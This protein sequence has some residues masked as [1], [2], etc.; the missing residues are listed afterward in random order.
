MET[1]LLYILESSNC[2]WSKLFCDE[3]NK[4]NCLAHN[5]CEAQSQMN[6]D[7]MQRDCN[8]DDL[9]L[10][11]QNEF[12]TEKKIRIPIMANTKQQIPFSTWGF[13][14]YS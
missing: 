1:E 5:L 2:E 11:R 9:D 3:N 4:M 12:V 8:Y 13:S 6:I 10:S 14:T 7:Q